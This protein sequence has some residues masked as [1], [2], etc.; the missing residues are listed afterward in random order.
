M[1]QVDVLGW[2]MNERPVSVSGF[3]S[4]I[5]WND[6]RNVPDTIQ[7]VFD[8]PSGARTMYDC[9]LANSFDAS[10]DMIYGSYA[11]LVWHWLPVVI[12][13][14]IW[15]GIF[16]VNMVLKEASMSRYPE[17]AAYKRRTGWLLP[18]L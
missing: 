15:I 17:W 16:A 3:G 13:A 7:T 14:W 4:I 9:T 18:G 12:L 8:Y 11:L 10:Y 5:Q 6:G 2:F 1:H